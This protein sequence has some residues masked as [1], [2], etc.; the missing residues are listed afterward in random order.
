LAAGDIV[1]LS[2]VAIKNGNVPVVGDG[3]ACNI[4]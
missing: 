4:S 2:F 3:C 1:D